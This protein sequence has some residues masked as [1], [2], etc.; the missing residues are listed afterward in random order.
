M[1]HY[2]RLPLKEKEEHME[3]RNA[4]K[5]WELQQEMGNAIR[6]WINIQREFVK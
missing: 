1:K 3:K 5:S 2:T 4:F 6:N